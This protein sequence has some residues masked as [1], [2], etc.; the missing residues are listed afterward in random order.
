MLLRKRTGT[1]PGTQ[2]FVETLSPNLE[3]DVVFERW[4]GEATT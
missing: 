4:N 3:G 2:R 1:S